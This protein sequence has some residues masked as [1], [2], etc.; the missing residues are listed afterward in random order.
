MDDVMRKAVE[1]RA[2]A[3]WEAGRPEG[4]GLLY[5]RRTSSVASLQRLGRE[6]GGLV[7]TLAF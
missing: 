5:R 1:Q 2:F 7:I 3:L 4:S 6:H